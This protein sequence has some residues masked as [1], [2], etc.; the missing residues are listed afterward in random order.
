M[1]GKAVTLWR[2]AGFWL[3]GN[4][5]FR[6]ARNH[7]RFKWNPKKGQG[8]KLPGSWKSNSKTC[9][10][11]PKDSTSVICTLCKREFTLS[12]VGR[13]ALISHMA[14]AKYKRAVA[15]K[16]TSYSLKYFST[17]GNPKS[18]VYDDLTPSVHVSPS[19]YPSL[20]IFPLLL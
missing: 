19:S 1:I 7:L 14:G 16:N 11:N 8:F 15:A 6:C 3:C 5:Y 17:S 20:V 13:Q 10:E 9:Q 12:N 18:G 4:F 2:P